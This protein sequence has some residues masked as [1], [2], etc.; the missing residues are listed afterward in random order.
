MTVELGYTIYYVD[1]VEKTLDFYTKAFG[2]KRRFL[3]PD[4]DYGELETGSTT[5]SFVANT[6]AE[7]N[8]AATDGF[9]RLDPAVAPPGI[10]IT[11]VTAE[12]A[13]TVEAAVAAGARRYLDPVE[14]PWGQT[15]AYLVDPNGALIE[16]G[17]PMGS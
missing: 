2:L 13:E 17:T 12:V 1:D 4:G 11:L 9:S 6:L 8:L 10:A 14:K 7:S 16:V 3:T 5:L 15:V